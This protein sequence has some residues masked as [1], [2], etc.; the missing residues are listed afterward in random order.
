M[1]YT[2]QIDDDRVYFMPGELV[3]IKQNIPN[4]PTMI[5]IGKV[6]NVFKHNQDI[7]GNVLK[8]IKCMWFSVNMELQEAIFNTK[9]LEKIK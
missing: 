3:R 4:R 1:S 9:D 5:V 7:K 2:E 6:S 8:G